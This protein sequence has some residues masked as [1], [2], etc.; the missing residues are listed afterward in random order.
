MISI[1]KAEM[2]TYPRL[3]TEARGNAEMAGQGPQRLFS[4]CT[5]CWKE[6]ILP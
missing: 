5:I 4:A 6:E 3:E 2:S 1:S